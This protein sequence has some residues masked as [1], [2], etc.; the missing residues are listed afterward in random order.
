[1]ISMVKH[2]SKRL[3]V[4]VFVCTLEHVLCARASVCVCLCV[5]CLFCF[6]LL[7]G[8]CLFVLFCFI[9]GF[10]VRLLSP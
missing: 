10:F 5:V 2:R 9:I 3:H 4:I 1:M 6:V 8:F 7:L